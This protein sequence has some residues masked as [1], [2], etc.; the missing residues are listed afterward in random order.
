MLISIVA[1]WTNKPRKHEKQ[2]Q[3]QNQAILL[4]SQGVSYL[5][6]HSKDYNLSSIVDK[7]TLKP[8]CGASRE[9]RPR[10]PARLL[11]MCWRSMPV[12]L[13]ASEPVLLALW[14]VRERCLQQALNTTFSPRVLPSDTKGRPRHAPVHQ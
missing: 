7:V 3:Q 10:A 14:P 9:S 12:C 2:Q 4:Q 6:A 13:C 5:K 1:N 8:P 11:Q